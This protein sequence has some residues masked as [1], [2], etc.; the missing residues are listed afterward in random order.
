[1]CSAESKASTADERGSGGRV[2]LC[3]F[4]VKGV[5]GVPISAMTRD[6]GDWHHPSP[7]LPTRI[8]KYLPWVIPSGSQIGVGFGPFRF[9][10]DVGDYGRSRRSRP[11]P[12]P[13]IPDWRG[14]ERVHPR[15]SQIGVGLAHMGVNWRR[16][17][18]ISSVTPSW[19]L[20]FKD[21]SFSKSL[22]RPA[23]T[24]PYVRTYYIALHSLLSTS[25]FVVFYL[26]LSAQV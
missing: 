5:L 9:T 10:R 4:V 8:P 24:G 25:K 16:F 7:S 19:P 2:P 12:S 17:Q 13:V 11:T 21:F 20:W 14:L 1:M 23:W 15:S 18:R 22:S 3:S 26:R 6:V